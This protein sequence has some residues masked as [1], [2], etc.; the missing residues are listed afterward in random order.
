MD[1]VVYPH[2][3][4]LITEGTCDVCKQESSDTINLN[5]WH[6]LGWETCNRD[7][8]NNTIKTWR[9]K[10]SKIK[11]ELVTEL[12]KNIRIKRK[13]NI[14]EDGWVIASDAY[15]QK[16]QEVLWVTVKCPARHLS[17]EVKL[18]DIILWNK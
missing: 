14:L 11:E 16:E 18:S 2:R 5:T 12:G 10:T 13:S 4:S 7:E 3:L 6:Y 15:Q 1:T 17:K 9:E 8:C